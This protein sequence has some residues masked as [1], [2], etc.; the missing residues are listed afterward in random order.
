LSIGEYTLDNTLAGKK[1]GKSGAGSEIVQGERRR[2]FRDWEA[3]EMKGLSAC[4][5]KG[6]HRR[7]K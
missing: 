4:V 5:R 7:G 2:R 3:E 6:G 1:Q